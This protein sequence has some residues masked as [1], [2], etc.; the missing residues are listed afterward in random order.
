M[1]PREMG[2]GGMDWINLAPDRDQWKVLVNEVMKF[3]VP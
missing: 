2:Y 3:R 1:D